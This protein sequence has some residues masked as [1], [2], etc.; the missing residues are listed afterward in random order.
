MFQNTVRGFLLVVT[1]DITWYSPA[2]HSSPT[3]LRCYEKLYNT[4][5]WSQRPWD[6]ARVV[7]TT[8]RH[9]EGGRVVIHNT[10]T[11][12]GSHDRAKVKRKC[13]IL[14]PILT[15]RNASMK[16]QSA[17]NFVGGTPVRFLFCP[18]N[19]WLCAWR[20]YK[21]GS[22][23]TNGCGLGVTCNKP[24]RAS[25]HI[26]FTV[27]LS[28]FGTFLR[29]ELKF[30]KLCVQSS[31]HCVTCAYQKSSFSFLWTSCKCF[32]TSMQMIMYNC[33]LFPTL[34]IMLIKMYY[35]GSLLNSLTP[36][37]I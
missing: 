7:T 33:L 2:S 12:G 36:H 29:S 14:G 24:I 1:S 11:A 21:R 37:N 35:N 34:S 10:D 23:I 32:G 22:Y 19:K 8:L 9:G 30:S 16:T 4:A 27:F 28:R 20:K 5:E 31:H 15:I 13:L 25:S 17:S 26:P 3:H 6:M 18:Q